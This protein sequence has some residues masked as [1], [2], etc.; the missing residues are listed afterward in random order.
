MEKIEGLLTETNFELEKSYQRK[1]KNDQRESKPETINDTRKRFWIHA[2]SDVTV[3][4]DGL[5]VIRDLFSNDLAWIGPVYHL[6]EKFDLR[7]LFSPLPDVLLIKFVAKTD[8]QNNEFL[9][10]IGDYHLQEVPEKSKYL[11]GYRYFKITNPENNN[12][13][14]IRDEIVNNSQIT[15][16][17]KFVN[18]PLI[19]PTALE[20]NDP[21][22][23]NQW[24]MIRIRAGGK[25]TTA[26]NISTGNNTVV[27]CI[28]DSGC[29]LTHPDLQSR[30]SMPGINLDTM[31]PD[32]S[33]TGPIDEAHGTCCA[34]VVAAVFNNNQGVAGLA[35]E[36]QIMPLAFENWTDDE[37]AVGIN[38]AADNGTD[39]ISMSFGNDSWDTTIIDPAIQ[40]AFNKNVV[41]CVAT[42]NFNSAITYPATNQLVM[43][44]GASDQNDNRKTP[45]SPDMENWGSNFGPEMSVVAPGV[46]IPT[47]DRQG[48]DGYESGDYKSDFNGTSSAT[49]QAAGLAALIRSIFPTLTNVQI[50][51]RIE[52]NTDKVG[53]V[54]YTNTPGHPNGTW[55]QEMG[56]GRINVLKALINL[57]DLW[58]A[59]KGSGNDNL[60]VMNTMNKIKKLCWMKQVIHLLH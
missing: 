20:P 54:T 21:D 19:V 60:N 57:E 23:Q 34:G 42:H 56:Y 22:F 51:D 9:H 31:L 28:L 39:V 17:V 44:C 16:D 52:K 59:W 26:W 7:D 32:G 37:V 25:G 36:C 43:A 55:D 35:G 13:Y 29:D 49:P 12:A 14:Q 15:L 41:M 1:T 33:P 50:R 30:Y 3:S 2:L 47:T 40:N 18:M 38:F 8:D 48:S 58:I 53:A 5:E 27:I 45:L 10:L 4:E 11:N 24:N 6:P 46:L